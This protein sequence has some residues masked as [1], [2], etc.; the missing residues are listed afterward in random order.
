MRP[1]QINM[2]SNLLA[3]PSVRRYGVTTV[4]ALGLVA[5]AVGIG[6][7]TNWGQGLNSAEIL[8][9]KVAAQDQEHVLLPPYA[10]P[11]IDPAYK[12]TVERPLFI[13]N[14][15]PAPA[16]SGTA[17][18]AMRKGQY[19]LTGTS[20]NSTMT[21]AFFV[22]VASG[23]ALRA[24]KGA[25]IEPGSGVRVDS[26][27]ATRVVLRQGDNSEELMLRSSAS[28][29]RPPTP[30]T[31][32]AANQGATTQPPQPGQVPPILSQGLAAGTPGN[33]AR[34]FAGAAPAIPGSS[35]PQSAAV[36]A[37]SPAEAN[38]LSPAAQPV[39]PVDPATATLQRRRRF[40]NLP[41]Q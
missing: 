26:V 14:R 1:S 35:I 2:L 18:T 9:T 41:P 3:K 24:N 12:E 39:A 15:R 21:V 23:K 36:A 7:E 19:K 38:S 16:G 34:Q 31:A 10:L 20:I 22:D 17:L 33:Q 11:P 6:V 4:L 27:E 28:P 29:P 13:S 25:E 30:V 8:P 32:V 40:Q 5:I 37:K